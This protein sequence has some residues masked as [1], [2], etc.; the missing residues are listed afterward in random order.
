M[1]ATVPT[2]L[3]IFDR[4]V[5]G[6]DGTAESLFAVKQSARLQRSEG[7]LSIVAVTNLAKAAHAGMAASHAAELL[8]ADAEQAITE[9]KK[10][11]P[12][13]GK[14]VN[15]DPATVL[16]NEAEHATL[17]ALGSHGRRRAIGL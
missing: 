6:V 12:A 1:N 2:D 5:C 3:R 7:S 11:V 16:L 15:G 10:L 13:E 8:Q 4:I 9:A 14:I 17:I